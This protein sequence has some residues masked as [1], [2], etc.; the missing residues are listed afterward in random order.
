ML[1]K[2]PLDVLLGTPAVV[3][4]LRALATAPPG[5]FSGRELARMA[6]VVPS[7]ATLALKRLEATNVVWRK[8]QGKADLWSLDRDTALGA[9]ALQLFAGERSIR[10]SMMEDIRATL[11]PLPV[12]RALIFGSVA[13]GEDSPRSD[14]DLFVQVPDKASAT[15]VKEALLDARVRISRVYGTELSPLV[16]TDG[17]CRR[18]PHPELLA[19]ILREGKPVLEA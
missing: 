13:R 10:Q 3:K 7:Q 6:G 16:Y 17:E 9:I 5:A 14:L 4:V 15:R 1:S 18:P 8:V 19:N 2:H 12:S 11:R